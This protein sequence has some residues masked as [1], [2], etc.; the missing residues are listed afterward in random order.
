MDD[1]TRF[2]LFIF[3]LNEL[4]SG[5]LLVLIP[6]QP[7]LCLFA[8]FPVLC[9]NRIKESTWINMCVFVH[10]VGLG[11]DSRMRQNMHSLTYFYF[12]ILI[13]VFRVAPTCLWY[14]YS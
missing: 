5:L 12:F 8:C 6:L 10:F 1:V 3:L 13:L 2:L 4:S 9:L 11:C 7:P 14:L